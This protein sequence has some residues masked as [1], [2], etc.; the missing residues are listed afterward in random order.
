MGL[1]GVAAPDGLHDSGL[2]SSRLLARLLPAGVVVLDNAQ[3]CCF[4]SPR[5]CELLGAPGSVSLA[6]AWPSIRPQLPL[7]ELSARSDA[8]GPL[9]RRVDLQTPLGTR[10]LRLEVHRLDDGAETRYV[11]LVRDRR[12]ID[13]ADHALLLASEAHANRPAFAG[14][15]HEAKGPLNNFQLTLALLVSGLARIES[16]PGAA[17]ISARWRH[18]F[19]VLQTEASRLLRCMDD[20]NALARPADTGRQRIDIG[21]SL[22]DVLRLLHHE[23]TMR[24]VR[25]ELDVPAE[26]AWVVGDA[27]Q[28]RL[29]LLGFTTCLI[30][31]TESGGAVTLH[32]DAP[33]GAE[34]RLRIGGS[35]AALSPAFAT[36]LFAIGGACESPYPATIAGRTIIEAHGGA[37]TIDLSSP[38]TPAFVV[39]MPAA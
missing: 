26:P 34:Q 15:V 27:R 38:A 16:L 37:V 2:Q 33:D 22:R 32:A 10:L 6:A 23:A 24:E 29:A 8:D 30:D 5:A 9:Q 17:T 36:T 28:L 18:Y 39:C 35:P 31:V 1:A 13:D 21:A 7:A 12:R 14:L 3:Q 4:A 25:L 20:I 11:I 19:D